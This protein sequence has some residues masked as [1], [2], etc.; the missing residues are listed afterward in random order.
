MAIPRIVV[1]EDLPDDS[2]Y[3]SDLFVSRVIP[4]SIGDFWRES[5]GTL[6]IE[7]IEQA[8]LS[9]VVKHSSDEP[10]V[11]GGVSRQVEDRLQDFYD[12]L[13]LCGW[14]TCYGRPVKLLGGRDAEGSVLIQH[15]GAYGPSRSVPGSPTDPI[16]N[17]QLECAAD[18]ATALRRL[19]G[20]DSHRR[21]KAAARAFYTGLSE[22]FVE[23]RLHQFAR[24]VEGFILPRTGETRSNFVS[25]TEL[26]VGPRHHAE[27]RSIYDL[28]S[29]VEHLNPVHE[30]VEG[31]TVAERYVTVFL[32]SIQ[33]EAIARYCLQRF[34]TRTELWDAFS[35]D[36]AAEALWALS[37]EER[38]DKWG[39]TLD[40][41]AESERFDARDVTPERIGLRE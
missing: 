38:Q 26:F 4:T 2:Q 19:I 34:L 24:C 6:M 31:G 14:Y 22:R 25:R 1:A 37:R 18:L 20:T 7:R 9:L 32:R 8:D 11:M 17:T 27:M 36:D 10:H 29:A 16:S 12:G 23:E 33:V 3:E 28:R 35:S 15:L 30:V 21:V 41:T 5:L 39:P 13:R 40:L